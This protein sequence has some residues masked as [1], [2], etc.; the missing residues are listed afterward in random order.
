M[1]D[2]SISHFNASRPD[3]RRIPD[4]PVFRD[5][6][7]GLLKTVYREIVV[8]FAP[9]TRAKTRAAIL[10]KFRLEVRRRNP[11]VPDQVIVADPDAAA[12]R[13]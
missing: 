11:L 7:S 3:G 6:R 4:I 5:E 12:S 9:R 2:A 8:R 10:R 13:L 1:V